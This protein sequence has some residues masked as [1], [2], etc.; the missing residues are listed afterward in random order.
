MEI[1]INNLERSLPSGEV[2]QVHWTATEVDGEHSAS[3]YGT[4]GF[5]RTDESPAFIDFDALT[6]SDVV[7][8]LE[9]DEGIEASLQAQIAEQKQPTSA[10]GMPWVPAAVEEVA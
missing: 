3:C 2:T 9:L 4:Q 5:S 6:E 8:W 10:T 7:G 1:S